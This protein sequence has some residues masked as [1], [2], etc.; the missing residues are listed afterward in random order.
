LALEQVVPYGFPTA[1]QLKNRI[2]EALLNKHTMSLLADKLGQSRE[3]L[4]EFREAFWRSGTPSVDAFLE[5]RPEF[6]EVGKLAIA[7]CLIPFENEANLYRPST[8]GDWYL[9]LSERLNQSFDE[10]ENNKLSIITFNYDRSLEYY[11]FNSLVNWHGKSV[12]E[13]IEK[14]AKVPIIHV[15]GQLGTIPYPQRGCRQYLP[16]GEDENNVRDALLDAAHGIT[17]LHERASDLTEAC[18]RLTLARRICFLGFSYHPLNLT[19]NWKIRT[20]TGGSLE[21]LYILRSAKLSG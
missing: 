15:Y 11:L 10:F 7:Y 17:L 4:L 2:C 18:R 8:D 14:L 21:L 9:H 20:C 12:D 3:E 5:G 16:L 19:R 13:C 1:K 6:L